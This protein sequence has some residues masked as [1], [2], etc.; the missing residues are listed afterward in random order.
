[1][2]LVCMKMN[3]VI[4]LLFLNS[5]VSHYVVS[6]HHKQPLT[7]E[8]PIWQ[9]KLFFV[10]IYGT[11][12]VNSV[13]LQI[14]SECVCMQTACWLHWWLIEIHISKKIQDQLMDFKDVIYLLMMHK[15]E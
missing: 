12:I 8:L 5:R 10:A 2:C 6:C 9:S 15:L 14:F 3:M 4:L 7:A 1:M 13:Y 11:N